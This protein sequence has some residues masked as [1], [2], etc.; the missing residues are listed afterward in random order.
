MVPK[1]VEKTNRRY[2]ALLKHILTV[3]FNMSNETRLGR[4]KNIDSLEFLKHFRILV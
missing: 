2:P 3:I 4:L 1:N